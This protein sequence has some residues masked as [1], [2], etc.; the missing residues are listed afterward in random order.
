MFEADRSSG[1]HRWPV[2]RLRT[3]SK[4]ELILCS[5]RFFE[6]TTHWIPTG[7]GRTVPCC[8]DDCDL[9]ELLPARGLFY[10]AGVVMSRLSLLELGSASASHFEQHVKLLH[11]GMRPGLVMELSRTGAKLPVRSECVREQPGVAPVPLLSLAIHAMALYRFPCAQPDEGLNQYS[12]RLSTLVR[13]R[14]V[15]LALELKARPREGV[16]L[17]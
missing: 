16:V 8:V 17:R 15:Q 6:L 10:V 4:T 2:V 9:C 5:D 7:R 3:G 14:N 13:R 1:L 12:T 11:G